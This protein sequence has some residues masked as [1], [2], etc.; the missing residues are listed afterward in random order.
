M[1]KIKKS[2]LII[3]GIIFFI[4][5]LIFLLPSLLSLFSK[6]IA[7]IDD[8][9]LQ[10]KKIEIPI[11]GNAYY[12]LLKIDQV[13]VYE[14]YDSKVINDHIEGK[15]WNEDLVE[16]ILSK[17]K[18][19]LDH[20]SQ[21]ARKLKFQD[22]NFDS[23]EK[24]Y[25]FTDLPSMSS[26]R[27]VARLSSLKAIYLEK[28]GNELEALNE[29]IKSLK[30]GQKIQGSQAPLIHYLVAIAI[31]NI[32]L[33]TTQKILLSANL[34]SETLIQYAQKLEEFKE[35]K[36]WI[37][38]AF[39]GE[40]RIQVEAINL[41]MT[42]NP[43]VLDNMMSLDES[44]ADFSK[45]VKNDFYFQ[46]N[47][48]KKIFAEYARSAINNAEK[49]CGLLEN[50]ETK[51]FGPLSGFKAIFTENLVG[52]VLHDIVAVSLSGV[53]RKSCETDLLVSTTQLLFSIKAYKIENEKY[54]TS[55]DELVSKY[56]SKI[57]ED[58]FNGE[59]IKYSKTKKIIYSVGQDLIDSG[60]SEGE[61]WQSMKDPTFKI[62]F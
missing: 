31:K 14:G 54:P 60:G 28:Q 34:P 4:F 20:F 22:P 24:I 21:A 53:Y 26:W 12:D 45:K 25:I 32:G 50:T 52:K 36:E 44:G 33:E 37:V 59:D 49:P 58:P 23:P 2:I 57:P 56:I 40:Y 9:D 55:L 16:D 61:D 11:E 5:A 6:D 3:I 15:T 13:F 51:L 10:L 39:K 19:A 18:E 41:I 35:N 42:G 27:N 8:S 38:T 29:A 7:S 1:S 30:I 62:N 48:T 46:P 17:N 43:E 47:K